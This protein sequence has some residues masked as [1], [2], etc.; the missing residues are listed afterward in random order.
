MGFGIQRAAGL[1]MQKRKILYDTG[2]PERL[3]GQGTWWAPQEDIGRVHYSGLI[4]QQ[5]A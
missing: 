5:Q 3:R 4:R 2:E 1:R